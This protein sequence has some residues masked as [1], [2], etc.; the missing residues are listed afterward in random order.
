MLERFNSP[1]CPSALPTFKDDFNKL[2][3]TFKQGGAA[4]PLERQSGE[5]LAHLG[6][7]HRRHQA[8]LGLGMDRAAQGDGFGLDGTG[9]FEERV[10]QHVCRDSAGARRLPRAFAQER[11]WCRAATVSD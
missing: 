10:C 4:L 3:G 8:K 2:D 5:R 11:A 9:V 7:R 1:I 6:H